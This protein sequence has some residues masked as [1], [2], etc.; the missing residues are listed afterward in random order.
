MVMTIVPASIIASDNED[1]DSGSDFVL[2][3][4][5]DSDQDTCLD[6]LL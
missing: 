1:D 6:L 5:D 3:E 2:D 4:N